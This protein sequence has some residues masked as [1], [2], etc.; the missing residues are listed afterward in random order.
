[1]NTMPERGTSR[2]TVELNAA[3]WRFDSTIVPQ[4]RDIRSFKCDFTLARHWIARLCCDDQSDLRRTDFVFA[5]PSERPDSARSQRI[6]LHNLRSS[7][8]QISGLFGCQFGSCGLQTIIG[9]CSFNG[10]QQHECNENS[11]SHRFS[12]EESV[13]LKR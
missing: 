6:G 4:S 8:Q 10:G 1:M 2:V 3:S 13:A 7:A 11:G 12:L 9:R 5:P